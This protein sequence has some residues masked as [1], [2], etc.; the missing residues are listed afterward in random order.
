MLPAEIRKEKKMYRRT[1]RHTPFPLFCCLFH[2]I[3]GK[4]EQHRK[5]LNVF[6]YGL[7]SAAV[8]AG[9]Q[10]PRVPLEGGLLGAGIGFSS[11]LDAESTVAGAGSL[12]TL[13]SY[14]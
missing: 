1:L 5:V 4:N 13:A 11:R 9:Q 10:F 6:D 12:L 14:T 7:W 8:G 3:L 2:R